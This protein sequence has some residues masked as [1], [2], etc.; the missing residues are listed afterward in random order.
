MQKET[1][2]GDRHIP[3][4]GWQAQHLLVDQDC[5]GR[6]L[7]VVSGAVFLRC[8]NTQILW[9]AERNTCMH[10]RCLRLTDA[11][12]RSEPG[13]PF[14]AHKARLGL[15]SG[16]IYD[17]T[18]FKLWE[19]PAFSL[20][21]PRTSEIIHGIRS[22]IGELGKIKPQP[23]FGAFLPALLSDVFPGTLDTVF[24][25]AL[26]V[27]ERIKIDVTA[28][29]IDKVASSAK[30]LVGLGSGLTPS[31][32]D[33]LGGLFFTLHHLKAGFPGSVDLDLACIE[34]LCE[35]AKNSTNRI[36]FTLLDDLLHG[37]GI[38]PLHKVLFSLL[39]G[40][41]FD[42]YKIHVY[43]LINIGNSTGWD[44]LTGVLTGLLW[45][46]SN[47]PAFVEGSNHLK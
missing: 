19:P 10:G 28:H 39:H 13:T 4:I 1:L 6:V 21:V 16:E 9:L 2:T 40:K 45:M 43:Q 18:N 17:L 26:P 29:H 8:E 12:P 32:D 38:E 3:L 23:G 30:K 15:H 31:G 27:L 46:K 35:F 14:H 24:N 22:I 47:E 44:L 41:A 11:L 25:A 34:P 5:S 37:Q 42:E 36:S 20:K 33:F 7:T